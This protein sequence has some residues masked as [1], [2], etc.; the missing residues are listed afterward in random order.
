MKKLSLTVS[1]GRF[2]G[3]AGHS[4][5]LGVVLAAALVLPVA[6]QPKVV[7]TIKPLHGLVSQVMQGAGGAGVIVSGAQS[8][9]VYALKPSDTQ[10]ANE[11]DVVFR[12]SAAFEPFTA[13]L[14]RS[15]PK[16]VEVVSLE[17]V[18]GL[19]RYPRRTGAT[20][21]KDGH[22]HDHKHGAKADVAQDGHLWLDPR[23]AK[24]L[25]DR[26]ADV[27]AR[28]DAVRA[29]L[30]KANAGKAKAA[31][32][33][34]DAELERD[35]KPL[36]GK[37]FVVFHDAI[38]YF[39][40]RYGLEATGSITVS[41]EIPPSAHRLRDLRKKIM[42]LAAVCVFSEPNFEAKVVASVIEGTTAR[43]GVIDPEGAR[44]AAGEGHYAD[45]L[46]AIAKNLKACLAS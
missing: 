36:A 12:M 18:P 25:V 7:V 23:N 4:A 11:A 20:F 30:Y 22:G 41:P 44:I 8:A 32:D 6:A 13:R 16:T 33:A 24:L 27:L 42:G 40:R 1:C 29:D 39:E 34:L 28:K 3:R 37:P 19:R 17:D 38:Q 35:M 15:L 43:T 21:E 2:L 14:I 45:M 9:H 46:R 31:L 26:I 10:A 5:A